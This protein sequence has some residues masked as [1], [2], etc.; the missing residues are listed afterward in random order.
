MGKHYNT[1][2]SKGGGIS[3]RHD[4]GNQQ[5]CIIAIKPPARSIWARHTKKYCLLFLLVLRTH[6]AWTSLALTFL[7][8]ICS[9][10]V[11]PFVF[12]LPISD[13][14]LLSLFLSF[15][16]REKMWRTS[17]VEG[18]KY[19]RNVRRQKEPQKCLSDLT[20]L[21]YER[22]W[23]YFLVRKLR[24]AE[25]SSTSTRWWQK[26]FSHRGGRQTKNFRKKKAKEMSFSL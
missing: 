24:K 22:N 25:K 4:Y 19:V 13:N 1:I 23:L 3:D 26:N 10:P 18:G 17:C 11:F 7:L 5:G 9:R 15:S 2:L 8:P 14:E 20:A 21:L 16:R 12:S 6:V